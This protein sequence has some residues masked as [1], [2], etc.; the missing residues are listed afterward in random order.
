MSYSDHPYDYTYGYCANNVNAAAADL[1]FRAHQA[2]FGVDPSWSV[3]AF[4]QYEVAAANRTWRNWTYSNAS[5]RAQD[6]AHM[7]VTIKALMSVAPGIADNFV[8]YN[9][10]VTGSDWRWP[11]AHAWLT[12]ANCALGEQWKDSFDAWTEY[13]QQHVGLRTPFRSSLCSVRSRHRRAT[14]RQRKRSGDAGNA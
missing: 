3:A 7:A 2:G 14:E 1:L 8:K 12:P 5:S 13:P 6:P 9:L 4:T 10:Q 11:Y